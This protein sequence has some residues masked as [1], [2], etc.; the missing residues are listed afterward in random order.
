MLT[1]G[2]PATSKKRRHLS[3]YSAFKPYADLFRSSG[4]PRRGTKPRRSGHA[5]PRVAA[6]CIGVAL[7]VAGFFAISHR[8]D[9]IAA[10]EFDAHAKSHAMMLQNGINDYL[11][12]VSALRA[13]FQ[14][15]DQVDRQ[16][17]QTFT[18]LLLR[19]RKGMLA[20]SWIPRIT[21][22]ERA[23]HERAALAEGLVGYRIKSANRNDA[24]AGAPDQSEYFPIFYSSQEAL[25]SA[26]YGLDLNDGG[27]R[28]QVLERA[29]DG[30]LLATSRSFVLRSGAGNRNGFFVALPVY[31]YGRAHDTVE[32]RRA[33]LTGFV[34]GVFQTGA[35]IEAVLETATTPGGLDLYIYGTDP[36]T[37]LYFHPSRSHG[38]PVEAQP[39]AM[40]G[41]GLHYSTDIKVGDV[42]W[43]LVAAPTRGGPGAASHENA[44]V[45]LIGG[46][47]V[48]AIVVAYL[49]A[50][51]RYTR[52][53]RA[54]NQQLDRTLSSLNSVNEQLRAQNTRF[55]AAL[56]NMSQGLCFF[57]RDHRLI[58]GNKRY[59]EMYDLDPDLVQPGI[60]LREV[61]DLRFEA[62]S[63]P[64]MSR[65]EYYVWRTS[66][67]ITDQPNDTVVELRNGRIF[68]IRHRSS[69]GRWLGRHPRRHHRAA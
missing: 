22:D 44:W 19:H 55:D 30:D 62:G 35:M 20:F 15:S 1:C 6:G 45:A 28:Q 60:T 53:L 58:V 33:N 21:R 7:S 9:G 5:W 46:L 8:A 24:V 17:F 52:R 63:F 14:A 2:K 64:A 36:S 26:V 54:G 67:A 38:T 18:D 3:S 34:Q 57:D 40:I 49:S 47:L 31:K 10:L 42:L 65:E 13:L 39:R 27:I 43:T 23:A 32:A 4:T 25:D 12:N 50:V 51:G 16:E 61:V 11:D 41:R 56:N 66:V 59:V 29:R 68:Q 69:A 37:A 48:T